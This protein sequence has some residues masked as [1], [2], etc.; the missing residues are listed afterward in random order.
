MSDTLTAPTETAP[1]LL[2]LAELDALPRGSVVLL[3]KNLGGFPR[4]AIKTGSR[5]SG[6]WC[7]KWQITSGSSQPGSGVLVFYGAVLLTP[8]NPPDDLV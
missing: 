8:T 7:E 3:T 4:A 5:A 1:R 6:D 2:T